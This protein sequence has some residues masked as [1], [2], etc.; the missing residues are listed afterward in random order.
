MDVVH[1]ILS[2]RNVKGLPDCCEPGQDRYGDPG[3]Q[4]DN[5]PVSGFRAL[6]RAPT[7]LIVGGDDEPVGKFVQSELADVRH[8]STLKPLAVY[9]SRQY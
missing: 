4:A 5:A 6:V 9:L 1:S 8:N 3:T 2:P 7:L